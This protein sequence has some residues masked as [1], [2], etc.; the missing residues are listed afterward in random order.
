MFTI[1]TFNVLLFVTLV[2]GMAGLTARAVG[3]AGTTFN[4]PLSTTR[5]WT[6]F[7]GLGLVLWLGIPFML[8]KK[9]VLA[10][11][12]NIPSPFM[13]ML[14]VFTVMTVMLSAFSPLGKR[15]ANGLSLHILFGFQAFRVAVEVTL[16]FLHKQGLT[17]VQMTIE[18]R[19]WDLVTGL[20]ALVVLV[21]FKNK[22]LSKSTYTVLNLIGLGLVINVVAVGFLSLPTPF[23]VFAGDNTWITQVPFVWLPTFFVEAALA[24]HI[25]SFRKLLMERELQSNKKY[26]ET[27]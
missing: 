15:L 25:I 17:H 12:S 20:L 5:L 8:A 16:M 21:F 7:T 19:N 6:L 18:G 23:Q 1:S 22:P 13:K 3:K 4:E 2:F 26:A 10:D 24:G 27:I 11:F 9:G 14:F